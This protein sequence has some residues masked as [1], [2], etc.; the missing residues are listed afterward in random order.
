VD[1]QLYVVGMKGWQTDGNLDGCFHRVRYTGMRA[2]MPIDLRVTKEGV[3]ITFTDALDPA[4][5]GDPDSYAVEWFNVKRTKGYG[6]KEYSISDPE[7]VGREEVAV[8]AAELSADRK[9]VLLKMPEIRPVTNMVIQYRIKA[10]DGTTM[11]HKID[12]TIH[13]VPN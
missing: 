6:S 8:T 10:A 1:G 7:Q 13:E 2:N 4:T 11:E 3:A 5:A 12:N 9:T